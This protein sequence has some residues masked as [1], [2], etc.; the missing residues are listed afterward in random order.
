MAADGA[1]HGT[2]LIADYQT[3]GRGR[4]GRSFLSPS[5]TGVYMSAILRPNCP[6]D[7]LL[8]LTCAAAVAA[9]NA[10]EYAAGFRPGIKWTNDLVYQSRKIAG[11]LTELSISPTTALVDY[12]V[13]G[14]GVNCCQ[15][16]D[17][18]DI[19][20]RGIAGSLA[21]FANRRIDR[22]KVTACMIKAFY[23]M[24]AALLTE[25][26]NI[27]AQYRK[28]CITIGKDVS[29]V[30]ADGHIRHGH[31][32]DVDSSG[33]LL[34]CFSDGVIESVNSGEVSVRGMYGYV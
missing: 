7:R 28:D 17:D 31:A 15:H 24:D 14:I 23:E 8:H 16:E 18:F 9:C 33:A 12:A 34:V 10:L 5:D 25:Q 21:M 26:A 11:I 6:P 4:L 3:G 20:I 30:R 29:L 2:I 19:S 1:P 27:I 32:L 22:A 13:V